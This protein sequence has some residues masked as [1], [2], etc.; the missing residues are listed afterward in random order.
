MVCL[1]RDARHVVSPDAE[2][3]KPGETGADD[4]TPPAPSADTNHDGVSRPSA[5]DHPGEEP[6]RWGWLGRAGSASPTRIF[7]PSIAFAVL[8]AVSLVVSSLAEEPPSLVA[9]SGLMMVSFGLGELSGRPGHVAVARVV[10][11][12]IFVGGWIV[13]AIRWL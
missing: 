12:A 5:D 11:L 1:E 3:P 6:N 4:G 8:A 10:G 13:V 7:A 2:S 9:L